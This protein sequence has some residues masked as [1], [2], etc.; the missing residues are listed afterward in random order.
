MR[1][2]G[3]RDIRGHVP[4]HPREHRRPRSGIAEEIVR[5]RRLAAPPAAP[6]QH[7]ASPGG[8]SFYA[9]AALFVLGLASPLGIALVTASALPTEWKAILAGLLALG[10]PEVLWVAAAAVMGKSGFAYLKGRLFALLRRYGPP[11]QVSRT[12]YR[13]GLVLF[14]LP[15]V[16]GWLGG[17]F[18]HHIPGFDAHRFP[19]N[20][21]GDLVFLTS[22]FVLGG[23]FWDKLKALFR[24]EA[25]A[26]FPAPGGPRPEGAP[27]NE[28]NPR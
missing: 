28:G 12:R 18:G 3:E 9:G 25:R 13:V 6:T 5:A 22:L 11:Q 23:D 7:P 1:L 2:R 20:M 19:I 16:F 8:W 24:Y 10:I 15:L 17:Y 21:A 4:S 27:G 14:V 26:V